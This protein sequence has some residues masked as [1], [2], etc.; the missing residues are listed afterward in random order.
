MTIKEE[1]AHEAGKGDRTDVGKTVGWY[2]LIF[3]SFLLIYGDYL[4]GIFSK[5][6]DVVPGW[7]LACTLIISALVKL[8]GLY[9][10]NRKLMQVGIVS[11]SAVWTGLTAVYLVY[12]FGIGYPSPSFLSM[13]L[14]MVI[15][16]QEARKGDFG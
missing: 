3:G 6:F 1:I 5:L 14:V 12:S 8:V 4:H 2:S 10:S 7:V 11:L 13:G 9:T 16:Y 15:C